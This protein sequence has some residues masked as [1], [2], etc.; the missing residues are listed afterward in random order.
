MSMVIGPGAA[1]VLLAFLVQATDPEA[2]EA[3]ARFKEGYRPSAGATG[4]AAAVAE[5]SAT[6]HEKTLA[7]LLPLLGSEEKGVREAAIRGLGE[8]G[9]YRKSVVPALTS[10]LSAS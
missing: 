4:R 7:R 2:D 6:V 9:R 5:L 3:L 1:W 10:A 8:F